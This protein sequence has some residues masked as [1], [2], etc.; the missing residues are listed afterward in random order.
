MSYLLLSSP[1]CLASQRSRHS[2]LRDDWTNVNTINQK[3]QFLL[4]ENQAKNW[5][6]ACCRWPACCRSSKDLADSLHSGL[7][8]IHVS[9]TDKSVLSIFRETLDGVV[10]Q[11]VTFP[12]L[13][14]ASE[15]GDLIICIFRLINSNCVILMFHLHMH[16]Y[17]WC[18]FT[19][20]EGVK[21]QGTDRFHG[22]KSRVHWQLLKH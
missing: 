11:A 9:L 20:S 5:S 1:P 22:N 13:S 2:E 6:K 7:R 18:R 8:L 19:P 21:W 16:S 14:T 12:H 4:R 3:E 17:L 10:L 15:I